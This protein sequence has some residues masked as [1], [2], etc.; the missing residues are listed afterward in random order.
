MKTFAQLVKD[1]GIIL[2]FVMQWVFLLAAWWFRK[3]VATKDDLQAARDGFTAEINGVVRRVQ[4]L[5]QKRDDA[6]SGHDIVKL[7]LEMERAR[8]AMSV[9][10]AK[11]EGAERL[12][13]SQISRAE[14]MCKMLTE[15]LLNRGG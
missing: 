5:E 2:V 14:E 15:H 12:V 9:F 1:Y 4:S 7:R 10:G 13:T 11:L 6:P 3:S 8:G